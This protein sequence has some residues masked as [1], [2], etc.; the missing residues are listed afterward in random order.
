MLKKRSLLL[1][2]FIGAFGFSQAQQG[3][4]EKMALIK[5]D[6]IV[7][8]SVTGNNLV[9][10]IV[11]AGDNINVTA[12]GVRSEGV[13]GCD[14]CNIS[15]KIVLSSGAEVLYKR[16]TKITFPPNCFLSNGKISMT[17]VLNADGSFNF[18]NV[19]KGTYQL[20]IGD[21]NVIAKGW[22]IG[23]E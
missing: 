8:P 2:A 3:Q 6:W 22:K 23:G 12:R 1:I 7:A 15:G 4:T 9:F 10:T 19:P 20:S 14:N 5:K 13:K 17:A 21:N 18:T 16:G 11:K